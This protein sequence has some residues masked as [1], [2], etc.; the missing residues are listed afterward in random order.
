MTALNEFARLETTGLW[1]PDAEAQRR[2]VVVSLGETT[3][4]IMDGAGRPL[5]HW[6]LPAI[7]RLNAGSRPATFS[8]ETRG[9]ETLEISDDTVIDAI[10]KVRRSI[11]RRRPHPGRLRAGGGLAIL[12]VLALAVAVWMPGALARQAVEALPAAKRSELGATILGHLQR[13]TGP[14][15]RYPA[16]QAALARLRARVL[17]EG[18]TGQAVVLP[19]DLDG[20]LYLPGGLIVLSRGMVEGPGDPAVV[21]G[22]IVAAGAARGSHDPIERLLADAGL[23]ATVTLLTTGDLDPEVLAAHA[24]HLLTNPP[25]EA[26]PA[27]LAAAFEAARVPM[28]PWA[29]T[30]GGSALA[31]AQGTSPGDSAPLLTDGDWVALQNICRN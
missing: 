7:Q 21:A 3:L 14:T 17:P 20:P 19:D 10:E 13:A 11:E 9:A 28:L 26:D 18:A 8:P 31:L 15:C 5:A 2:E 24:R 23:A 4:I 22:H 6:S 16:G 25:E 29:A 27:A 30:V 12:A 1:R